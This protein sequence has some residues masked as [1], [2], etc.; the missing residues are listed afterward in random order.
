M[1]CA[2]CGKDAP[3]VARGLTAAGEVIGACSAQCAQ[4]VEFLEAVGVPRISALV[5]EARKTMRERG[6]DRR[7]APLLHTEVVML[8]AT[9]A[10]D[11]ARKV[12][13]KGGET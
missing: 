11:E 12:L 6:I 13:F 4:S 7:K 8:M 10:Y 5:D 1:T 2:V 3:L 9:L